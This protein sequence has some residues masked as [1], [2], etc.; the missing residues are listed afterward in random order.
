MQPMHALR[1][2]NTTAPFTVTTYTQRYTQGEFR[3][4]DRF[5]CSE[6]GI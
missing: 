2:S 3:P 1:Q 6:I 5:L 4:V